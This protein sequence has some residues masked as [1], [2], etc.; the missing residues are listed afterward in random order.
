M[1]K[2]F[3]GEKNLSVKLMETKEGET[4]ELA[5]LPVT[6]SCNLPTPKIKYVRGKAKRYIEGVY[7]SFKLSYSYGKGFAKPRENRSVSRKE[8]ESVKS[9]EIHK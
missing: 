4:K 6:L 5:A 8:K 1:K 7:R 9:S 2:C 3:L